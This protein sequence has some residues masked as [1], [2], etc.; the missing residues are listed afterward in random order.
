MVIGLINHLV[1]KAVRVIVIK[2]NLDIKQ[3]DMNSKVI[4]TMFSL[5]AELEHDLI[6][7]RTKEAL[8]A[9]K[10][11]GIMVG[12]PKGI[13]QKSKFDAHVPRIKELLSIGLSVCKIAKVL[14]C[15]NHISLSTYIKKRNIK[16]HATQ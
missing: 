12:K 7:A 16:A 6:S 2:Q 3:H 8:A 9:K 11:Q 5:F 15:N 13:I 4:V 1:A 10:S 14:G